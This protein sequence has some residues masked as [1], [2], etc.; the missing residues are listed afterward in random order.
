MA[1]KPENSMLKLL[2]EIGPIIGFFLAYR[3]AP[4]TEGA[5]DTETQLDQIMFATMVF[6]PLIIAALAASW[7]INKHLPRMAVVTAILVVVFGGLTL[8]LRDATF[9]KMKPTVLYALFAGA[10]G[11][12]L[13]RGVSYL[14]LLMGDMLPMSDASWMKFTFRFALFFAVLAVANELVWRNMGT[15]AWVN[16]KTFVLPLATFV[17]VGSQIATLSDL[18]LDESDDEPG[19]KS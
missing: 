13:L 14:K 1:E 16:F 5:G 19:D 3:W 2:L 4:V 10:L 12:G 18:K 8:W 7:V 17:F 11:F 6:I 15:D 9:I